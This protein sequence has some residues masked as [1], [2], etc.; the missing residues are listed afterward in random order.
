MDARARLS[1][2][3][4]ELK[5]RWDDWCTLN[6]VTPAEG[7]RQLILDAVAADEPEYRAGCTDVMHSLPVGEHR[8]RPRSA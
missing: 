4:G 2:E 8:K 5:P 1:I 6:H 3:L 7:V